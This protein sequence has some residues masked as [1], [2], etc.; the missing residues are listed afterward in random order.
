MVANL[1]QLG[2]LTRADLLIAM[3]KVT[4][5]V[6]AA[7]GDFYTWKLAQRVYGR[8]STEAWGAVGDNDSF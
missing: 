6:I 5:G 3:P 7:L 8:G 2:P 4:Q 1:L